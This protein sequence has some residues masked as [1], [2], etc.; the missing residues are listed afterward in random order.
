[1][2]LASAAVILSYGGTQLAIELW[3]KANDLAPRYSAAP[4]NEMLRFARDY[5]F[6]DGVILFVGSSMTE[7]DIDAELMTSELRKHGLA[8]TA[9]KFGTAGMSLPERLFYLRRYLEGAKHKPELVMLE[10]FRGYDVT[11]LSLLE[12]NPFSEQMIAA[13]D[14]DSASLSARWVVLEEGLPF[15]WR[16]VWLAEIAAHTVVHYSHVGYLQYSLQ[17]SSVPFIE[18]QPSDGAAI[19]SSLIQTAMSKMESEAA[20]VASP[21]NR[22]SLWTKTVVSR[23]AELLGHYSI[24]KIGF[25]VPPTL[26]TESNLYGKT[27]CA[28]VEFNCFELPTIQSIGELKNP[29]AWNDELHLKAEGRKQYTLWLADKIAGSVRR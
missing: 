7:H 12:M 3:A 6:S 15:T 4:I 25:Y 18:Q 24:G 8:L 28:S 19:D 20:E 26:W 11:P 29:S 13:M 23:F 17:L 5:E 1:M 9:V 16:L 22:I 21:K 10:V 27:F 14:L 2:I